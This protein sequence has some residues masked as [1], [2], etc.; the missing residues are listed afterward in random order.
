MTLVSIKRSVAVAC[1][2]AAASMAVASPPEGIGPQGF[3]LWESPRNLPELTFEDDQGEPLAL[4]D[5]KGKTLLLNIWAT[6][7]GP[8]REEMPTLDALQAALGG[9]G[10]EVV[11]LSIDRKGIEVVQDFYE[12]VGIEHLRQYIDTTGM[13]GNQ[14]GAVGIPTTL[15]ID[16]QGDEIGRL[17]GATEWDSSEMTEFLN[18]TI[19][20]SKEESP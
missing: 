19:E 12:D 4:A 8:C 13:A 18:D 1:L 14:L 17:V 5:F 15:L 20:A 10:F 16:P 3:M 7:C 2:M 11:A 9:E 6:W